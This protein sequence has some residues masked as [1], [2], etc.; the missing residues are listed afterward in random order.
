MLIKFKVHLNAYSFPEDG[1]VN[2]PKYVM[3][4]MAVVAPQHVEYLF[5]TDHFQEILEMY[6]KSAVADKNIIIKWLQKDCEI[7]ADDLELELETIFA[8]CCH[9]RESWDL[10]PKRTLKEHNSYY[11]KV[12]NLCHEL[13]VMIEDSGNSY[14]RAGGYGLSGV[15]VSELFT[16][17]EDRNVLEVLRSTDNESQLSPIFSIPAVSDVLKRLASAAV[18][19]KENG[20]IHNQPNKVGAINGYFVRELAALL[21]AKYGQYSVA[22]ISVLSSIVLGTVIDEDLVKKHIRNPE[23][24]K[25]K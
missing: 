11:S 22:V 1:I 3:R 18:R 2:L 24:S 16:A 17:E 5:H 8:L 25:S 6:E 14:V 7:K 21:K 13:A 10:L 9:V 4:A 20:P 23:R 12:E 15:R 19:I